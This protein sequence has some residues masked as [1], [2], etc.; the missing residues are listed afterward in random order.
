MERDG[1]VNY[2]SYRVCKTNEDIICMND[3]WGV[4]HKKGS[5]HAGPVVEIDQKIK[6]LQDQDVG[7]TR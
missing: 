1:V 6:M 5:R 4:R 2:S 3:I 7:H